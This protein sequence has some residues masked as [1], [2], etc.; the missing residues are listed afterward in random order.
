MMKSVTEIAKE[1]DVCTGIARSYIEQAIGR[2][3]HKFEKFDDSL[4]AD[5]LKI[6]EERRH[7]KGG[8]IGPLSEEHKQ[9][10]KD[11][12]ASHKE[13][14]RKATSDGMKGMHDYLSTKQK[15]I[16]K[17]TH[18]ENNLKKFWSTHNRTDYNIVP[19]RGKSRYY[20]DG[21]Y[22]DSSYEVIF[23]L[24]YADA[25]RCKSSL[26]Y[27]YKGITH[28]YWPDFILDGEYYELKGPQFFEDGKMI[29]PFDR[30]MD[31]QYEAKHQCMIANGVH[32]ITN[33]D[34][35]KEIVEQKYGKEYWTLF[36]TELPFPYTDDVYKCHK[37][38]QPS[39]IEAWN[40]IELRQKAIENRLKYGAFGERGADRITP[41]EV[42]VAFSIMKIAQKVSV[43][44]ASKAK[45]LTQLYLNDCNTIVDPFAGFGG[46]LKGVTAAGKKYTGFDIEIK[47]GIDITQRDILSDYPVEEYDALFTCPPYSDKEEWLNPMNVIKSCDEW[48]DVCLQK[49]KCSK[50]LFVVDHTEKYSDYV[51]QKIQNNSTFGKGAKEYVILIK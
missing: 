8:S 18:P 3:K 49:F 25:E 22:Y 11:W 46:R 44:S 51:V 7:N 27:E 1:L 26:T 2:K 4:I 40:N 12:N 30:T 9:K 20:Y 19:F 33:I 31:D 34:A 42:V 43:F 5:C 47:D 28:K 50:Y 10:I 38:G 32:I 48:I 17:I 15:E 36:D 39:P 45:K 37:K 16:A 23:K 14:H 29:N 13:E 24:A 41:K 21:V 6:K 35:E